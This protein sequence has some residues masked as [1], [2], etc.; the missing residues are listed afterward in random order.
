MNSGGGLK[1][2]WGAEKVTDQVLAALFCFSSG[3]EYVLYGSCFRNA[4]ERK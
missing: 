1:K 4:R 2:W 3:E